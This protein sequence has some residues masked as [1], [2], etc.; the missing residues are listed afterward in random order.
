MSEDS[1]ASFLRQ[2]GWMAAATAIGGAASFAAHI[3][4]KD[5]PKEEYG[6]FTAMLQLL[7][8]R[9]RGYWKPGPLLPTNVVGEVA[10]AHAHGGREDEALLFLWQ[11]T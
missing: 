11:V 5:M 6:G 2:S 9:P 8:G 7:K 3:F 1:K 4:A 10:L